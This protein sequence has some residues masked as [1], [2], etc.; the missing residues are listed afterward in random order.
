M[1]SA[2]FRL[3]Y[4]PMC[5]ICPKAKEIV[6]EIVEALGISDYKEI[7]IHSEE[8]EKY[9]IEQVPCLIINEKKRLSG[10]LSKEDI[11]EAL[12]DG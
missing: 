12:K 3:F 2:N 7:N 11:L 10:V 6:R 5:S 4:S 8:G 1:K 9:G